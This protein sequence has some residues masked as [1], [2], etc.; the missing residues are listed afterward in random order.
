L[1]LLTSVHSLSVLAVDVPDISLLA[2]VLAVDALNVPLPTP[3]VSLLVP[4]VSLLVPRVSLPVLA[5]PGL[6]VAGFK[7]KQGR[8]K[9][10]LRV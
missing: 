10:A 3:R 7:R 6:L 8:Y 4:R 2:S 1:P 9:V 5:V